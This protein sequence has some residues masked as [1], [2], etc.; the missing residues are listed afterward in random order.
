[1]GRLV[2]MEQEVDFKDKIVY[3]L[4]KRIDK[5]RIA[6]CDDDKAFIAVLKPYINEYANKHKLEAFV[7]AYIG[8][9]FLLKSE[10]KY[11]IIYLDYQMGGLDGMETA[12]KLRERNIWCSIIFVTNYP[13]FVYEAFTVE[14]F[15]FLRKPINKAM[16]FQTLDDYFK[17][18]GNDYPIV[19][20]SADRQNVTVDTKDIVFLEAMRKHC[21]IHTKDAQYECTRTMAVVSRMLPPNHFFK[22]N[23]AFIVNFNHI[24][25]YNTEFVLFKNGEKAYISRKYL[26]FFKKAYR[27]YCDIKKPLPRT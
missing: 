11:D 18:Y 25:R 14:A 20:R 24:D 2:E 27:D 9:E 17:K 26:P 10:I 1:M 3:H 7:D 8:G 21:I 4:R 22:I 16:V 13:D 6:V 5:M 15:R 12:R 19:L 23:K